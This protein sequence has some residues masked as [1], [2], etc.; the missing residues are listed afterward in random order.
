MKQWSPAAERNRGPIAEVLAEELPEAGLVLEIASGTGQHATF[1]AERLPSLRWQPTDA[2]ETALSSIEAYRR[3]SGRGHLLP[4]IALDV[5]EPAWPIDSAD[6]IV[7]INMIH[8]SAWAA[9]VG[10]FRGAAGRLAKH[11]PLILYGPFRF[12]NEFTA[13]SNAAFDRSLRARNPGWGVR[14]LSDLDAEA[15]KNGFVRRRLVEMPANNHVVVYRR[16]F[17]SRSPAA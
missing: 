2:D 12:D 6:A 7:C 4:P 3:D 9:T 5:R 8:I 16:V 14:D 15:I 13:P 10:L 1:F 17:R 11:G